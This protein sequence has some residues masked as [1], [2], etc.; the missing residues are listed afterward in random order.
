MATY[1]KEDIKHQKKSSRRDSW[2]A[3]SDE[4]DSTTADVFYNRR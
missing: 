1:S 2:S 4:K 3:N